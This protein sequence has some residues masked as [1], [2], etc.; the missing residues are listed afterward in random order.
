MKRALLFVLLTLCLAG[1]A[2]LAVTPQ[3]PNRGLLPMSGFASDTV[4]NTEAITSSLAVSITV[5][6]SP[7]STAV[8]TSSTSTIVFTS[9]A[10]TITPTVVITNPTLTITPTPVPTTTSA[11]SPTVTVA[12]T[13]PSRRPTSIPPLPG[14]SRA[15]VDLG[16][17]PIPDGYQFPNFSTSYPGD[18]TIS[19]TIKMFGAANV[20]MGGADPCKPGLASQDFTNFVNKAIII[21]HCEGFTITAL[22]Y[23]QGLDEPASVLPNA[24]TTYRL[25]FA[26]SVRNP[27]AYYWALQIPD[28]VAT[29]KTTSTF[30]TPAQVLEQLRTAIGNAADPT[31]LFLFNKNPFLPRAQ[32]HTILPYAIDQVSKGIW[33]VWVYD[34]NFPADAKRFVTIN[35]LANTWI[36]NVGRGISWSGSAATKSM[37]AVPLSLYSQAPVCSFCQK[38]TGPVITGGVFEQPQLIVSNDPDSQLIVADSQGHRQGLVNGQEVQEIPGASRSI[39]PGGLG[40]PETPISYLPVTGT[41]TLT[42]SRPA[43]VSPTQPSDIIEFGPGFVA[44]V[45]N[46]TLTGTESSQLHVSGDGT[47]VAYRSGSI[48]QVTFGMTVESADESKKFE[49]DGI[50]VGSARALT[51]T[52]DDN[53]RRFAVNDSDN[54]GSTYNLTYTRVTT[55]GQQTFVVPGIVITGTDTQFLNYDEWN[56][57]GPITL[58]IDSGSTGTVTNTLTLYSQTANVIYL[59]LIQK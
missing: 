20:C 7:T 27:I 38:T 29:A 31:S 52:V 32:G 58:T 49:V 8:V 56:G 39:L 12:P 23:F 37:G 57:T 3:A 19:D 59:P 42:L 53:Q 41:Y 4:T 45:S 9:T 13:F 48:D 17:R 44:A 18:F 14:G 24:A 6:A 21:G 54:I 33:R 5:T 43:P 11:I 47:Q 46:I 15:V 30:Q 1:C 26:T 35:T 34:N 51:L 2:A 50:T 16:F 40:L 22:R 10:S 28:P 25:P 36:Y 55:S